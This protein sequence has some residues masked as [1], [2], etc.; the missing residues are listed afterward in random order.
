MTHSEISV[1]TTSRALSEYRE[2]YPNSVNYDASMKIYFAADNF[3]PAFAHQA[4]DALNLIANGKIER[5]VGETLETDLA[6]LSVL[7]SSLSVR[8]VSQVTTALTLGRTLHFDY[9]SASSKREKRRVQPIAIFESAGTW[10]FRG[11]DLNREKFRVF[12]FSRVF[13]IHHSGIPSSAVPVDTEWQERVTVTLM[14]HPKHANPE[15]VKLDLGLVNKHVCNINIR[16]PL[17]G[18]LLSSLRVDSSLHATLS[19]HEHQLYLANRHELLDLDS[20]VIAPGF[21]DK[22]VE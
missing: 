22:K 8:I 1:A 19:P 20:M 2:Q 4:H 15:A 9:Y 7:S 3:S 14:P 11:Y 17:V 13:S 21:N 16:K 5:F 10:Y 18:F 12:R 6:R